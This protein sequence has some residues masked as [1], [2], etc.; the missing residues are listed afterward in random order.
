MSNL[1][2]GETSEAIIGAAYRVH[3]ALGWDLVVGC[4]V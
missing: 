3:N 1:R 4:G 2:H